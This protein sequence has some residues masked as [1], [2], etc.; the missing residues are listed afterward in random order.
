[1]AFDL[2][3]SAIKEVIRPYVMGRI[4]DIPV[5]LK[6]YSCKT[7]KK[8]VTI[9]FDIRDKLLDWNNQTFNVSFRDGKCQ[10]TKESADYQIAMTI[11]SLSTLLLGYKTAIQL[12]RLERINGSIEAINQL[13]DVLY[14]EAPCISDYI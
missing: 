14:H 6:Q 3:D 13:N 2:D 12:Y 9:A 4:I 10:L 1:M 11:N 8:K 7:N 5:F